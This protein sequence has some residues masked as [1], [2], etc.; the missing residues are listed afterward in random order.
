MCRTSILAVIVVAAAVAIEAAAVRIPRFAYMPRRT[1]I[2]SVFVLAPGASVQARSPGST[3]PQEAVQQIVHAAAA[4]RALRR[5]WA[6]YAV[7]DAEGRAGNIDAA[8]KILGG[9]APQ[10]GEAAMAV[11][12]AT[13]LYRVDGAFA[14]I[15]AACLDSADDDSWA[16]RL[17][18]EEFVELGEKIAFD[19]QKAD[20]DFYGVVF[21]SKGSA[22]L[23]KIYDEAKA[24]VDRSI[25]NFDR[26]LALLMEVRAPGAGIS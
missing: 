8:R 14:A 3:D 18:V 25:V 7:I 12:K 11:A 21:A 26:V 9:V 6:E 2:G 23:A 5:D 10:R 13:P 24:C 15:R 17:D 1:F 20:G 4:L 16:T 22:Q 19:L